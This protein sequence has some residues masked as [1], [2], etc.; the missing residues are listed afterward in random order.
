M[1]NLSRAIK[2]LKP[3]AEFSFSNDDYLTIK[4][5]KLEGKAPT[6]NEIDKAI[7]QINE[8]DLVEAEIRSAS[9][10]ALLERIGITSEEAALLLE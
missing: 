9:R 4:W 2:K 10:A 6:Q 3:T 5:D 8:S 7:L 1:D